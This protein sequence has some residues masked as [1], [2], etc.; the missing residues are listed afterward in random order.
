MQH[1]N[2]LSQKQNF[3]EIMQR[4]A[5]IPGWDILEN[6]NLL[7][8]IA[9]SPVPFVN[10]V[11]GDPNLI[12]I[13]KVKNFYKNKPFTWL[14]PPQ[15][16]ATNLTL[17]KFVFD[18]TVSNEML[19][20][21]QDYVSPEID[22]NIKV[23]TPSTN[24]ELDIWTDTAIATFG[25]SAEGFKEFFYPLI[26][27]AECTPFLVMYN[28]KPAGT[29]MVYCGNEAAGIYTMSTL[30][31]YRRKGY[32]SAATNACIS[33]AKTRNLHYAVLDASPMGKPLYEKL[34]FKTVQILREYYL[35]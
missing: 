8:L 23:I 31:Q 32:G 33:F 20:N 24:E 1:Y 22:L 9:P 26:K 19:L 30:E 14:V 7:A 6:I 2:S 29:A 3:K 17:E 13:Q 35:E 15:D 18:G 5:N 12:N 28:D 34:G 21:L 10:F 27:F 16:D 4:M 11:W 25:C